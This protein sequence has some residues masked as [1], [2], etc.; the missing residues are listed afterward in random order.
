[1]LERQ[2]PRE[3]VRYPIQADHKLNIDLVTD[4]TTRLAIGSDPIAFFSS[5]GLSSHRHDIAFIRDFPAIIWAHYGPL[6]G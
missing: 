5:G 2:S 3:G 4:P 1:M 6:I